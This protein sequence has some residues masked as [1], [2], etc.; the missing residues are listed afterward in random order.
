[1]NF[2]LGIQRELPF[3]LFV[4]ANYVGNLGRHLIR[5]PDINTV[6]FQALIDRLALPAAQRPVDNALR[7]YLGYS[8]INQRRSDSNSNYNAMQLYAAKRRGDLLATVS[9]TWSKA[10][11]DASNFNDNLEDP[12]NRNFNYGVATFDRRHIFVTTYTYAPSFF[13]K[14][15]GLTKFLLDGY[16][17]SG[18]ARYQSGRPYTI[19]GN[20]AT[21]TRRADVL[22]SGEDLYLREDRQWLNKAA[23]TSAPDTRRGT[24]GVGMVI[25]PSLIAFD[26]SLRKRIRLGENRNLRLQADVFN[27]FNRANFSNISTNVNAADFGLLTASG[28]GRS[29]QLGIKFGF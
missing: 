5:N 1:M 20:T 14:S 27:A 12:F 19:T 29:I 21:G 23:F 8:V 28:P 2:S 4:E 10:L 7:P 18:I 11:T 17:I 6:P 16:E 25:G 9:Y 24:S 15:K 26:F 13:R 22:L 3:G